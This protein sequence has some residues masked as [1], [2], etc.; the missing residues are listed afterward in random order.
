M[1]VCNVD[2][3]I[4]ILPK[5]ILLVKYSCQSEYISSNQIKINLKDWFIG[6]LIPRLIEDENVQ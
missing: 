3:P 4:I 2:I 1:F 6:L 5:N